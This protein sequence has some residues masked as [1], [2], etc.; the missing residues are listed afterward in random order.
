[1]IRRPPRSTLSS[2]SAASDVYKRQLKILLHCEDHP[3]EVERISTMTVKEWL[4]TNKRPTGVSKR[5]PLISVTPD[6]TITTCL[7]TMLES[8]I[9]RLPVVADD[10]GEN[11]APSILC[12]LG[13]PSILDHLVSRLFAVDVMGDAGEGTLEGTATIGTADG[14]TPVVPAS[15]Q[16]MLGPLSDEN[17][18]AIFNHEGPYAS[19]FD[20]P[21]NQLKG[22]G[23]LN[24]TKT[25]TGSYPEPISVTFESELCDAFTV[26]YTH[27]RAHET[28]EH[29]VCR[30]LLEKKK[31]KNQQ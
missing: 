12:V 14:D 30:L 18:D 8:S 26:S 28:P 11:Q 16:N 25:E 7:K 1:M 22:L 13:F 4:S 17:L 23:K 15:V 2:S 5:G 29:L 9:R 19:I 6:D 31:K 10:A 27:L 21:F 3:E 24:K 20:I